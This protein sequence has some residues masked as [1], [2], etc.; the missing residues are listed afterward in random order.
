MLNQNLPDFYLSF[1]INKDPESI[2]ALSLSK[3]DSGV[4]KSVKFLKNIPSERILTNPDE[5]TGKH[6]PPIYLTLKIERFDEFNKQLLLNSAVAAS[7]GEN[8]Y[9]KQL[10]KPK[11]NR[12]K[13][14][15]Q[16]TN[17]VLIS[18]EH[19]DAPKAY[20]DRIL[21]IQTNRKDERYSEL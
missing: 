10:K 20:I 3:I 7:S 17:K 13:N 19:R 4:I 5:I 14:F 12:S 15:I 18:Q 9:S 6:L 11:F 8:P 16:K 2:K 1:Q 21:Q